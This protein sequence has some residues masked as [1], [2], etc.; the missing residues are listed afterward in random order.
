MEINKDDVISIYGHITVK[1]LKEH[2]TSMV[3][4]EVEDSKLPEIAD[5]IYKNIENVYKKMNYDCMN[6][7]FN[8]ITTKIKYKNNIIAN[9]TLLSIKGKIVDKSNL[10]SLAKELNFNIPEVLLGNLSK[11]IN[12]V[13]EMYIS[14]LG[15][16]KNQ[17]DCIIEKIEIL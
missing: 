5:K 17:V 8:I 10:G 7:S 16:E 6:N 2:S 3:L 11:E 4:I 1:S 9:N 14:E 15:T 13:Y 12:E